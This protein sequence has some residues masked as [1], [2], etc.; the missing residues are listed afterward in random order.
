MA[1]VKLSKKALRYVAERL[2]EKLKAHIS[3]KEYKEMIT[4]LAI[5]CAII[6]AERIRGKEREG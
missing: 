2:G 1:K 3:D 4:E 6:D 5:E